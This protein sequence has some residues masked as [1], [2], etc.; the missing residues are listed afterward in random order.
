[1]IRPIWIAGGT[2]EGRQL[3]AALA[4]TGRRILV[5]VA[6]DYGAK[7]IKKNAFC[8]GTDKTVK[9]TGYGTVF[10][11]IPAVTRY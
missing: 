6:T 3:V 5:T 7:L 9:R 4:Y 2:T 8:H 11:A 1:M 10:K